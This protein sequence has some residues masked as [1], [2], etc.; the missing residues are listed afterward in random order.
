MRPM[1]QFKCL[2][3]FSTTFCKVSSTSEDSLWKSS[4]SPSFSRYFFHTV[5]KILSEVISLQDSFEIVVI[6]VYSRGF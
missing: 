1:Y 4:G 2:L 5:Y 6:M 3:S